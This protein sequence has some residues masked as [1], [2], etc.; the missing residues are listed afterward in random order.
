MLACIGTVI[1]SD[2]YIVGLCIGICMHL[3]SLFALPML[4]GG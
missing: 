3:A 4:R 2:I 1:F